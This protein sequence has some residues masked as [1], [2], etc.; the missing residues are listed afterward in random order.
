MYLEKIEIQG[1]KSFAHKTVLQ[2]PKETVKNKGITAIVGPNGSGKS[3]IADAVKWVLGEQ[4]IKTLRAKKSEDVI[5]FGSDKKARLGFAEVSLFLN[6]ED[7]EAKIEYSE[8]VI[9]RRLYRTGESEYLLNKNKVR[10]QDIQILL[11]KSHIGQ[12]TYSVIGQGMIDYFLVA[13][14]H[15]RKEFFDEAAGVKEYQIKRNQS[16]NKLIATHENLTKADLLLQEI[17]P[18]LKLLTRQMKKLEKREILVKELK[19]V[20]GDYYG[21]LKKKLDEESQSLNNALGT[22][23]T[24]F[25]QEEKKLKN[26]ENELSNLKQEQSRNDIFENL[27]NKFSL[28]NDEKNLLLRKQAV[29]KGNKE[30]EYKKIG[31]VNLI[32]LER[33]VD[34][35]KKEKEKIGVNLK[36]ITSS[37]DTLKEEMKKISLARHEIE[38]QKKEVEK[39]LNELQLRL[40]P[41]EFDSNEFREQLIKIHAEYK[42]LISQL[43]V[44]KDIKDIDELKKKAHLIH[45]NLEDV[46]SKISENKGEHREELNVLKAKLNE[47]LQK[48]EDMSITYNKLAIELNTKR[49]REIILGESLGKID[50]EEKNL[51]DEISNAQ[52][53]P[54]KDEETFHKLEKEN[55]EIEKQINELN[56]K[57]LK[58]SQEISE[59]NK[60]EEEKKEKLFNLQKEYQEHQQTMNQHNEQINSIK[61]NLAKIETKQED[62][63]NEIKHEEIDLASGF[64]LQQFPENLIPHIGRLKSQLEIIGGIDPE[65][66]KEYE[67]TKERFEFLSSQV[68]DL[69]KAINALEK[70]IAELDGTIKTKFESSFNKINQEF[71]K[72]FKT[73]FNGGNAKLLRVEEEEE[74]D[75][76]YN[77]PEITEENTQEIPET[78][79]IDEFKNKNPLKAYKQK[80]IFGIDIQATPPGKKVVNINMLSGG[81]RTLTAIALLCAI[82][83]NN[84]APFIILDEVDAALDEANSHK[85]SGILDELSHRS[86]FIVITHNRATMQK[87]ELLY[88][89]TMA[90]DGASKLLS[91]KF[92]EAEK[93]VRS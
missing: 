72:Y 84:P 22:I 39:K 20:Q 89:V 12:R 30:V 40:L 86:Q 6:N 78:L 26:I 32:W 71:Q 59:F 35:I 7:G 38:E 62:L 19:K 61:I 74:K 31:K 36:T 13:P 5:F 68:E 9:T 63:E 18:R 41:K 90:D 65:T 82:I 79:L 14:P 56:G 50:A 76:E 51:K 42:F 52:L 23:Q 27:K 4:S 45:K 80:V 10:L 83:S 70:V 49:E 24:I 2:F 44:I 8:I 66:Q 25:S 1:F 43:D 75:K 37:I 69:K 29:I 28:L 17:E 53:D 34:E 77:S 93:A 55:E 21:S 46:I 48:K 81:E 87:A 58:I 57:I 16:L 11:A 85:L 91:I 64:E 47:V 3:N 73:L 88:G 54:G 15:E 33:K 67:E 92:E 60:K